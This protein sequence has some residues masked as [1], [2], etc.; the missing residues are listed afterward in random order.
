MDGDYRGIKSSTTTTTTTTT[1][2]A[3]SSG[4]HLGRGDTAAATAPLPSNRC[5][6]STATVATSEVATETIKWLLHRIGPVLSTKKFGRSLL[7]MLTLCY[8]NDADG[9]LLVS[10]RCTMYTVRC[11]MYS[12]RRT[13]TRS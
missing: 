10:V 2:A 7:R 9:L 4:G 5:C 3:I 8:L 11:A 1:A 6:P 12:V 13:L